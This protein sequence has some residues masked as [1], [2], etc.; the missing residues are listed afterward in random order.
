MGTGGM[1]ML[2]RYNY[3]NRPTFVN[4]SFLLETSAHI[5]GNGYQI[6][7]TASVRRCAEASANRRAAPEAG[8]IRRRTMIRA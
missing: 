6:Y 5:Y 4:S 1:G 7:L 2:L 3:G 8:C